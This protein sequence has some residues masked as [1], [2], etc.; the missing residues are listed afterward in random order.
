MQKQVPVTTMDFDGSDLEVFMSGHVVD[1]GSLNLV[2]DAKET[3]ETR[4]S[5]IEINLS[6]G[7]RGHVAVGS[8][9]FGASF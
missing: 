6:R 8:H 3:H 9:V 5:V 1:F 2:A 4:T 7:A